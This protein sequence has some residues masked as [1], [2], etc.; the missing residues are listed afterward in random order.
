MKGSPVNRHVLLVEPDYY[1]KYPPLGLL[2]LSTY[3]KNM[4]DTIE[5]IHGISGNVVREPDL[6]YIKSLFTWSWEPVWK[7]IQYYSSLFP[8]SELWLGGLYASLMPEHA[9]LSGI[10]KDKIFKGLF[11]YP[12]PTALC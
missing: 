7:A 1:T 6:V 2:K 11:I 10:K 8:N 9:V 3:H 4:G 5:F 12:S